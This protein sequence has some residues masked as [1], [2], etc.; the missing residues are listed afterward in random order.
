MQRGMASGH[1][2]PQEY[3]HLVQPHVDSF[4]FFL[5]EGL[6]LVVENLEP[7]EVSNSIRCLQTPSA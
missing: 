7:I 4:D 5:E 1:A 6:Q 2:V 3:E